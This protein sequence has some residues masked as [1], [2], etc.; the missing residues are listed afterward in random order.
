M[1]IAANLDVR[2]EN[3]KFPLAL[4]SDALNF[5]ALHQSSIQS[6]ILSGVDLFFFT[7]LTSCRA[8]L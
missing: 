7:R 4:T 1:E 8:A 3:Y 5:L 6:L 2:K